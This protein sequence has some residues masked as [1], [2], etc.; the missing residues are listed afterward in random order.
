V[1][2]YPVGIMI[3]RLRTAV[4]GQESVVSSSRLKVFMHS[5]HFSVNVTL[6]L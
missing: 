2:I 1:G 6:D 3:P 5:N 4:T